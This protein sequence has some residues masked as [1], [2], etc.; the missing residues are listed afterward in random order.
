MRE[1]FFFEIKIFNSMILEEEK[2]LEI[3]RKKWRCEPIQNRKPN[4]I[5]LLTT[6]EK[7]SKHEFFEPG[8]WEFN[9]HRT[10]FFIFSLITILQN[11][12]INYLILSRSRSI[13][14]H[15]L[16]F[17]FNFF[18][19]QFFVSNEKKRNKSSFVYHQWKN[20]IRV[21]FDIYIFLYIFI[22]CF[23]R[24]LCRSSSISNNNNNQKSNYVLKNSNS[25]I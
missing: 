25:S 8:N 9:F 19:S 12:I 18:R 11:R 2:E 6:A 4:N 23:V 24:Y 21:I 10:F 22:F 1:I 15:R 13:L 20:S 3:Q 7:S 16:I 14:H 17:I 5:V